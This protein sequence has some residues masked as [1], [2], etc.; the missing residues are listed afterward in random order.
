MTAIA[1]L[2]LITMVV[3]FK[4]ENSALSILNVSSTPQVDKCLL[5][6]PGLCSRNKQHYLENHAVTNYLKDIPV[7]DGGN[8][9]F[10][11]GI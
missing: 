11:K 1:V 7:S 10:P 6:Y 3:F 2:L 5:K 8:E 4:K 9:F